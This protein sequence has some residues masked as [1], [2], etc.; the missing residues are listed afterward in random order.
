MKIYDENQFTK[1]IRGQEDLDIDSLTS[2][3]AKHVIRCMR[4][5]ERSR[6]D[7]VLKDDVK[8]NQNNMDAQFDGEFKTLTGS[9]YR[10]SG[11]M[12]G[13][14]TRERDGKDDATGV[15]LASFNIHLPVPSREIEQHN[16]NT[17]KIEEI[18]NDFASKHARDRDTKKEIT[19]INCVCKT[20]YGKS[21]INGECKL[22]I[23][24][25]D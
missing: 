23:H 8:F 3:F 19:I 17:K 18:I 5:P 9:I 12:T 4:G 10:Y 24:S 22:K 15:M 7:T 20:A 25:F 6:G 21:I 1:N 14:T 11:K 13:K 16:L 2:D